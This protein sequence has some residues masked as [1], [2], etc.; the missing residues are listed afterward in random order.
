[1][2]QVLVGHIGAIGALPNYEKV[3]DLSRKELLEDGTLGED[4]DIE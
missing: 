1:M 4:F 3:L 2:S